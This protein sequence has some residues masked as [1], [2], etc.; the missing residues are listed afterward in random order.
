MVRIC[1]LTIK[2]LIV[3]VYLVRTATDQTDDVYCCERIYPDANKSLNQTYANCDRSLIDI[4]FHAGHDHDDLINNTFN[5]SYNPI[6]YVCRYYALWL[7]EV[8]FSSIAFGYIIFI[9]ILSAKTNP[10]LTF[11][12]PWFLLDTLCTV[13]LILS[14]F[15]PI[16]RMVW[17]P[18]FLQI[19]LARNMLNEAVNYLQR[20]SKNTHSILFYKLMQL[21]MT[22]VALVVSCIGLINHF[23]RSGSKM[24]L[25]NTFWFVV[26]TFSTVGYGDI[27]PAIWPSKLCVMCIIFLALGI[28]PVQIE[29]IA[30][31]YMEQQKLTEYSDISENHVVLCATELRY[32]SVLDFLTEFYEFDEHQDNYNVVILCPNEAEP[33]LKRFLQAPLWQSRVTIIQG[34]TYREEDLKRAKVADAEAVF[35][36]TDRGCR[37]VRNLSSSSIFVSFFIAIMHDN[38]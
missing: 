10:I 35:V 27:Y 12:T 21:L 6:I 3:A 2:L 22:F 11:L 26:V 13:P 4:K 5:F 14:I 17:I 9:N 8:I 24:D 37:K 34:S 29:Q 23:E 15:V 19:W 32:D 30:V 20:N 18:S 36:Q 33:A 25:F 16:I 38:N 31:I 1:V 7:L 28:I